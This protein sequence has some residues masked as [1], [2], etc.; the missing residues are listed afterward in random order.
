M[1][2]VSETR[3]GGL[4]ILRMQRAEMLWPTHRMTATLVERNVAL[5]VS[6]EKLV[7]ECLMVPEA[8]NIWKALPSLSIVLFK[9]TMEIYVGVRR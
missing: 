9:R 1:L 2:Y 7:R 4:A 6:Y 3:I 5:T 8:F